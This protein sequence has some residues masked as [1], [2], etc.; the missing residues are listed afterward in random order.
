MFYSKILLLGLDFEKRRNFWDR[1]VNVKVVAN[2]FLVYIVRLL[3][4]TM[5]L[6]NKRNDE[7]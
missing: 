4:E 6:A 2:F 3:D 1:I 7:M 5:G